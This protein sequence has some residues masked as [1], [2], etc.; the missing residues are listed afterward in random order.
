[1]ERYARHIHLFEEQAFA[2]IQQARVLVAGAGGLGSTVLQ[3]LSRYGFGEIHFYD[4]GILDAPDLNRQFLYT[5]QDI[6]APKADTARKLMEAINP[7]VTVTAHAEQL[8]STTDLPDV[9]LVIDCLDNFTGRRILDERFFSRGIP[10][11]HGG[12][13]AFCGQVTTLIPGKTRSLSDIYGPP[14][15]QDGPIGCQDIYP[16]V[17]VAVASLQVSEAVK[18]IGGRLDHLLLNRIQVVD[19]LTNSFDVIAV[20]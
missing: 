11:I 18:L 12:V 7:D 6:G 8:N 4:D 10:I 16:P 20:R 1:M 15:M 13:T 19:L 9:D 3:L 17:V 14:T 5:S 2:R